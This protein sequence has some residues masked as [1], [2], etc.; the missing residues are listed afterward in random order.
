MINEKPAGSLLNVLLFTNL[1]P[2]AGE[3]TRGI[4]NANRFGALARHC[5]ARVVAPVPWWTR[6]RDWRGML[7]TPSDS[8]FGIEAA[9]PTY[10]S[11]PGMAAAHGRC[12]AASVGGYVRRLR[13]S[14]PFDVILAAWAYPDGVAASHLAEEF[15]CPLVTMVLGSD[16]NEFAAHPALRAQICRGLSRSQRVVAVSGALADRVHELDIP[17]NRIVVQHNGVDGERFRPGDRDAARSRLGL[18]RGRRIICYAGNFKPEKGVTV[19]IDAVGELCR[20]GDAETDLVLVGSGP[21]QDDLQR[22]ARELGIEQ[23]VQFCGRKRHEELPEWITA[24]DV[25]CLPSFR[26]GCPNVVLEALAS[27]RP[28]VA[29]SVGGVP[30]LLTPGCGALVPAGEAPALAR[31]LGDTLGRSWSP[32]RLRASVGCLSWDQYGCTLRDALRGAVD[33]WRGA[34]R[35]SRRLPA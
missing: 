27:G 25:F 8:S 6:T 26:E 22:R 35:P 29:S 14:F 12:M 30:E 11:V 24:S 17:R 34:G 16:I 5:E 4:F 33:E 19:L 21:L 3:P 9:F 31:A 15:G 20:A 13:R 2:S 32:E 18:Q 10:W 23:R 7:R 1:F 28:V